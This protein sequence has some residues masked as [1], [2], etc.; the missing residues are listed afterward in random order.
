M[1]RITVNAPGWEVQ[2]AA[3]GGPAA[4]GASL[5]VLPSEFLTARSPVL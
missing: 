2:S 1:A 4:A 5:L 3:R